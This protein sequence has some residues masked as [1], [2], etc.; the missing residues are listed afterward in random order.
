MELLPESI[1]STQTLA[2]D[3][4]FR[5]R[6]I[7]LVADQLA[8]A[9]EQ[10]GD[11]RKLTLYLRQFGIP[12]EL[13]PDLGTIQFRD[14]LQRVLLIYRLS[15]TPRSIEL[16]A[17][18]VGATSAKVVRNTFVLDH[19]V[20]ALYN[21]MHLYDAGRQHRSFCVDVKVAGISEAEWPTFTAVFRRLFPVFQPVSVHLRHLEPLPVSPSY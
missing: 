13:L 18:A 20:Q 5:E 6:L 2:L 4:T 9:P 15:G 12:V 16:L 10:E 7:S 21:S 8:I 17:E 1:Q 11:L 3:R 14:L 19:S